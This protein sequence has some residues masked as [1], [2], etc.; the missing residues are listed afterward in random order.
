MANNSSELDLQEAKTLLQAATRPLLKKKLE[1][2]V[3]ELVAATAGKEVEAA[4]SS[5]KAAA[6]AP[7]KIASAPAQAEKDGMTWNEVPSFAWDQGEHSSQWVSVYLMSGLDGIGEVKEGVTCNFTSSS[8]DLKIVGL[9]GKN[10]RLSKTN[11]DKEIDPEKSKIV[12]KKDK[13]TIKLKK[14][15]GQYGFEHW[16]DLVSKKSA[17]QKKKEEKDPMSGIMDLMKNMYDEGDDTMKKTIGEAMM[18]QREGG[19]PGGPGAM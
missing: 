3:A 10:Y 9:D 12:V 5:P 18:K 7:V 15:K 4:P 6:Q 11:L 14:I 16:G 17:D 13:V 19:G 8:F 1:A 2:I